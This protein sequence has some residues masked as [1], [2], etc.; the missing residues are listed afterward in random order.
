MRLSSFDLRIVYCI[1]RDTFKDGQPGPIAVP[2]FS[3]SLHTPT[4]TNVISDKDKYNRPGDEREFV[5]G[6]GAATINIIATFPINKVIF[7]QQLSG[8]KASAALHQLRHEGIGMLYRGVLPPLLQKTTSLA[9]M[10]GMYDQFNRVL[11]HSFPSVPSRVRQST[12][13]ILAGC[14]EATL[15]PF[16]RIQTLLQDHCFH[17]HY[18]NMGHAMHQIGLKHGIREY[19]RGLTAILIRNGPSNAIFFLFRG[20]VKQCLPKVS[21]SRSVDIARNFISGG[22]LGAAIST[23]FFPV[24]VAKTQM[25]RRVGGEFLSFYV[26]FK[27]VYV[28]RNC[29]LSAMFRGVHINGVR[30]L[31]SWGIINASYETLKDMFYGNNYNSS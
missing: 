12:A 6:W 11:I 7:R 4:M 30:S 21:Q 31:L 10:F 28:E 27:S 19:Y 24:N 18:R 16:E 29:N 2:K 26:A 20:E 17:E 1:F 8:I 14:V 15:A 5:C 9:L 22:V 23:V 13:A 3:K 25:Q